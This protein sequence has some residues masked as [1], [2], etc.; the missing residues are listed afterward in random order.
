[1]TTDLRLNEPR[2]ASLPNIMKAKKKP[3]DGDRGRALGV[4]VAPRL[5]VLKTAEPGGR[6]AGVKVG[7]VA[8]LVQK[9]KVEAGVIW[10]AA[11]PSQIQMT[12]LLVAE[13]EHGSLK[14]VTTKALTAAKALGGPV[15]VLVAG[16]ER[17]RVR[18]PP[19]G[20][21]ASRRCSSPMIPATTTCWPSR[22][23]RSSRRSPDRM[24][25]SS[26]RPPRRARMSCRGS[27]RSS[28]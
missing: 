7:S 11:R 26:R 15:H 8:E 6:K 28:T 24:R 25:P 16:S 12:T 14:D 9:L 1:M 18:R 27:R 20:S 19:P 5:K 13:H 3:L 17:G 2:Y 4:D 22:S 23:R 10:G 21:T